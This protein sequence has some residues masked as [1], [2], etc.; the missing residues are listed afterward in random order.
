MR[1]D[2]AVVT[3]MV[4]YILKSLCTSEMICLRPESCCSECHKT[5]V[6]LFLEIRECGR[7]RVGQLLYH[8]L[9]QTSG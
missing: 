6:T 3:G 1:S 2:E 5:L 7:C 8:R 4:R 9:V